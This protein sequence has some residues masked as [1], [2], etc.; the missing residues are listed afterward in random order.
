[1][2]QII[3]LDI[4]G[5]VLQWQA[6][7]AFYCHDQGIKSDYALQMLLNEDFVE[8]SKLFG[9]S[10]RLAEQYIHDYNMSDYCRTLPAYRDALEFIEK[11][12]EKYDFI[13]VTKFSKNPVA[14][15]NRMYNLHTLFPDAFKDIYSCDFS[16]SKSEILEELKHKYRER[17]VMFV[18]DQVSNI[19]ASIGI[20]GSSIEHILLTRGGKQVKTWYSDYFQVESLMAIDVPDNSLPF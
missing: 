19:D 12:K 16:E 5:T 20:F 4:D 17:I 10:S 14:L 9:V 2:K 8:P 15:S 6:N 11:Y 3:L 1:M 7:L 18:D 13:A